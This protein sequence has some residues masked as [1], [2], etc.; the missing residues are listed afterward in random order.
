MHMFTRVEKDV[1]FIASFC[2]LFCSPCTCS[3]INMQIN[4][5]ASNKCDIS[6]WRCLNKDPEA[7]TFFQSRLEVWAG[8]HFFTCSLIWP[9]AEHT[10]WW[11]QSRFQITDLLFHRCVCSSQSA[12]LPSSTLQLFIYRAAAECQSFL[13][14]IQPSSNLFPTL[15]ITQIG[16]KLHQEGLFIRP[17]IFF[18]KNQTSN[19]VQAIQRQKS[20]EHGCRSN[21]SRGLHV[22]EKIINML[23]ACAFTSSVELLTKSALWA[24]ATRSGAAA[25]PCSLSRAWGVFQ[26][27]AAFSISSRLGPDNCGCAFRLSSVLVEGP[28]TSPGLVSSLPSVWGSGNW[29]GSG[30]SSQKASACSSRSAMTAVKWR[31]GASRPLNPAHT[32]PTCPPATLLFTL[33]RSYLLVLWLN[34]K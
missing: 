24:S 18:L 26:P 14:F 8:V 6:W 19:S 31:G 28:S 22:P 15:W 17:Q 2:W 32:C 20:E 1:H 10:G 33:N 4:T 34:V 21:I 25:W 27:S 13:P 5:F 16:C 12:A 23:T 29:S 7:R 30:R 3:L 11:G 9:Q